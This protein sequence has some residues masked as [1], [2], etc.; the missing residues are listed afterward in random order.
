MTLPVPVAAGV[1]NETSVPWP[2]GH[3]SGQFGL[4][5][6]SVAT[7]TV[8]TPAGWTPLPL[9]GVSANGARLFAYYRL[10]TSGAEGNV[11]IPGVAV[12]YAWGV[13]VTFSGVH[14]TSPIHR[15][16]A[17]G[18]PAGS[19]SGNFPAIRTEAPDVLIVNAA[20]WNADNAGPISSGETNADL[21][22]LTERYDAGTTTGNGGGIIVITGTKAA[23]GDVGQTA[24]TLVSSTLAAMTIALA[25]AAIY[26]VADTYEVGGDPAP[27]GS[28]IEVWDKTIGVLAATTTV[29]GGVGAFSVQVPYNNHDYRVVGD[30][31]DEHPAASV[32]DQ[33]V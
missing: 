5:L 10:A 11:T 7:E 12:N 20:S 19:T 1:G 27:D 2:V 33:A 23:Q 30:D 28:V 8:S 14:A 26:T 24:V 16:A 21:G 18:T 29:S 9:S 4:L 15:I 25:P 31:G 3:A 32:L 6:V 17:Y 13:I 22:S